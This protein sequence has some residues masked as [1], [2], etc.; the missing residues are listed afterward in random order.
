MSENQKWVGEFPAELQASR[1]RERETKAAWSR[2]PSSGRSGRGTGRDRRRRW[3]LRSITPAAAC[4][5]AALRRGA[6][7]PRAPRANEPHQT[8]EDQ[9]PEGA[10]LRPDGGS[11]EP[12]AE[13]KEGSH[14][15]FGFLEPQEVM[16]MLRKYF[17]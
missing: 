15:I 10:L 14:G 3:S 12:R 11:A 8:P 17:A 5:G 13:F 9:L 2:R 1:R 16:E 7:A 4:L 6:R